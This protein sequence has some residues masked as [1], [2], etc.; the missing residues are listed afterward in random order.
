MGKHLDDLLFDLGQPVAAT[1]AQDDTKVPIQERQVGQIRELFEAAGIEDQ[2]DRQAFV[3][4]VL[5]APVAGLR[6]LS[7]FQALRVVEALLGRKRAA[8][9]PKRS[10][11]DDREED[12]WIDRL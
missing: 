9:G 4:S 6:S 8:T 2:G 7:H 5:E 1:P 10:A 11:W 3:E 12:T